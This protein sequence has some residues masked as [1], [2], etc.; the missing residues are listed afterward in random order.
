MEKNINREE[1]VSV[2]KESKLWPISSA[3]E[4]IEMI[5]HAL[6]SLMFTAGIYV[7]GGK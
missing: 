5:K 7:E 3:K 1:V 2:L 4:R 6:R